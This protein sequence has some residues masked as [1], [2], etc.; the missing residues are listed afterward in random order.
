MAISNLQQ[1]PS[2]VLAAMA[3]KTELTKCQTARGLSSCLTLCDLTV[4]AS[5]SAVTSQQ[6]VKGVPEVK[7]EIPGSESSGSFFYVVFET[8]DGT[9]LIP[10]RYLLVCLFII[11]P[12]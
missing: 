3:E 2:A 11:R 9:P 5:G 10:T 1:N 7:C 6:A 4:Q 12:L 8:T